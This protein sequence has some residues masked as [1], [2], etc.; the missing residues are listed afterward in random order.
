MVMCF[1]ES[2]WCIFAFVLPLRYMHDT[3]TRLRYQDVTRGLL[4]RRCFNTMN[5]ST[6]RKVYYKCIIFHYYT[7][8]DTEQPLM[9]SVSKIEGKMSMLPKYDVRKTPPGCPLQQSA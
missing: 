7:I 9:L 4:G 8:T 3:G 2:I 5:R 1:V 6:I